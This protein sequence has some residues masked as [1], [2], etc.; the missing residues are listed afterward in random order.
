MEKTRTI[1]FY[2][3]G[4]TGGS[5]SWQ[6]ALTQISEKLKDSTMKGFEVKNICCCWVVHPFYRQIY[7]RKTMMA[8]GIRWFL[9]NRLTITI[10]KMLLEISTKNRI[11]QH[12]ELFFGA[13]CS[14]KD[15]IDS[16]LCLQS[17]PLQ[18][19]ITTKAMGMNLHPVQWL[20]KGMF[21]KR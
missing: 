10:D 18:N 12:L 11:L 16:P 6:M 14:W 19:L 8:Y 9:E 2:F 13:F 17:S 20:G 7:V 1:I 5:Q 4:I 21:P 3:V 15:A